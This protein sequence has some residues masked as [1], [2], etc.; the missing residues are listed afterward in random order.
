MDP[1]TAI[2]LHFT[3]EFLGVAAFLDPEQAELGHTA[4][5]IDID[6]RIG[7]GSRGIIYPDG[8]VFLM[9]HRGRCIR[10]PDLPHR[11]FYVCPAALDIDLM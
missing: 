10:K 1:A 11:H 9:A 7:V 4:V 8:R 2:P 5:N 3:L 6:C